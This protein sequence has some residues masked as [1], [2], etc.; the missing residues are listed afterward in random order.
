M[1]KT[2]LIDAFFRTAYRIAYQGARI[3]WRVFRPPNRG[4]LV[5]IW[6]DGRVLLVKNSYVKHYSLPGGN[7]RSDEQALDAAVRE[8]REEISLE[9]D[10]NQLTV[11]LDHR[12][13]WEGRSDHVV[14]FQLDVKEE[15]SLQVDNREV[16]AAEWLLPEEALQRHLFPPLRQVIEARAA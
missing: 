1:G 12:H 8:L 15:P 6:C 7:L 4:A 9:V 13:E 5:A 11:A 14:I 16:V 10:P 2:P 3:Y